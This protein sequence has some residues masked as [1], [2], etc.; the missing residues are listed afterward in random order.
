VRS[1]IVSVRARDGDRVST[2]LTG[3]GEFTPILFATPSVARPGQVVRLAGIGFPAG[4]AVVLTWST[5]GRSLTV[6]A[7]Q[8]G[9]VD[10]TIVVTVSDSVGPRSAV[11]ADPARRYRPAVSA[12]VLVVPAPRRLPPAVLGG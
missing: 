9:A 4:E 5:G 7:D 8:N 3:V 10:T 1:G 11:A 12:P 6:L 2:V